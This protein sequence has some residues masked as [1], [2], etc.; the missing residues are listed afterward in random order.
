MI[1][2]VD[3]HVKYHG[4]RLDNFCPE[5]NA[6]LRCTSEQCCGIVKK[7][8]TNAEGPCI[9]LRTILQN[10]SLIGK[11]RAILPSATSPASSR[12]RHTGGL[13]SL[14]LPKSLVLN[15]A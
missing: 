3:E 1:Q 5:D 14:L 6:W 15:C 12:R 9:G 10:D 13:M 2:P 7:L 4:V 8:F 11:F